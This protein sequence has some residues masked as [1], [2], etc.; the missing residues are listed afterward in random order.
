MEQLLPLLFPIVSVCAVQMLTVRAVFLRSLHI[1]LFPEKGIYYIGHIPS[2]GN[3]R[4]FCSPLARALFLPFPSRA[5]AF[6]LSRL[7]CLASST[8]HGPGP[9]AG[10]ARVCPLRPGEP[11]QQPELVG[12]AL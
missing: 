8:G 2:Q 5:H 7:A 3:S 6:P 4:P 10:R 9:P 12:M 1:V 11:T